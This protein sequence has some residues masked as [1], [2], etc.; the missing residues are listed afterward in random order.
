MIAH[1]LDQNVDQVDNGNSN[2]HNIVGVE[3]SSGCVTLIE[4][5]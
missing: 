5:S 3:C 1:R 2:S 4:P